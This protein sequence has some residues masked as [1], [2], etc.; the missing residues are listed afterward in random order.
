M[1][2]HV[3]QLGPYPPPEGGISRNMLAIRD[4]LR[5]KGHGCS[6]IA[7][8]KTSNPIAEPNVYHPRSAFALLRLLATTKHDILHL[9]LGGDITKRVLAMALGCTVFGSRRSVLT[10]HSGAWPLTNAASNAAPGSL[11]GMIFRRFKRLIAVNEKIAD[12]FRRFGV[13]NER[14][15]VVLPFSL[16]PPAADVTVPDRL[17]RFYADHKPVLLA[18]GGL[19][20]DYDP[21]QQIAALAYVRK[22]YPD[23][24]LMIVGDGSMRTEVE[25]MVAKGAHAD[26]IMLAG[27]VPHEVVLHLIR[28]ADIMLRTTLFDGDAISVREALYLGTPVIATDNGMRP[29]GVRLILNNDRNALVR[30]ILAVTGESKPRHRPLT[31]LNSNI[32]EVLEIYKDLLR[33]NQ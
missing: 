13:P 19:E 22:E 24:G 5:S 7:T 10:L 18:V 21:L 15:K 29:K 9:H 23:A 11:S 8:S 14:I 31:P 33:P 1:E 28:D 20:K 4:E 2:M 32:L 3:L 25:A 30:E 17:S 16:T 12:V 6:I 27:N 26:G